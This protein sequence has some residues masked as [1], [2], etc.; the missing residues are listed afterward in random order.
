MNAMA[1]SLPRYLGMEHDFA[2][3]GIFTMAAGVCATL[4]VLTGGSYFIGRAIRGLR[5]GV[6]HIDL[7]IAAGIVAAYLGSIAG[8]LLN[9]DSL[10][11]FDFVAVFTFLMLAGRRLQSAAVDVLVTEGRVSLSEVERV[12]PNALARVAP[13]WTSWPRAVRSSVLGTS[14]STYASSW[15]RISPCTSVRRKSR[16]WKRNV[17]FLC[18]RPS[19]CS[20]VA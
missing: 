3:A 16:P 6:L 20:S 12:V 5:C 18:S 15:C 14:R 8:W 7:P 17:S 11:Y 10:L 13:R 2:L 9:S 4:A 1:F 19:R